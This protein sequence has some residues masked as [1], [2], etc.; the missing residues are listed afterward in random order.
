MPY[1]KGDFDFVF[2]DAAKGQYLNYLE[3]LM[4]L[5]PVGGLILADNVLYR[6]YVER[7]A[8]CP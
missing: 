2:I 3:L 4:D 6:G 8:D 5:V 7:R 1:L